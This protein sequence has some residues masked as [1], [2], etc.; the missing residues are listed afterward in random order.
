[1][2]GFSAFQDWITVSGRNSTDVVVQSELDW[3]DAEPY[4]DISIMCHVSKFSSGT[5]IAVQTSPAEDDSLFQTMVTFSP[6]STG[7]TEQIVRYATAS[8][9]LARLIRW[10]ATGASTGWSITF[11]LFVILKRE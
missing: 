9:P 8:V 3:L 11:R 2:G 6:S 7:I 5:I 4:S 10:R 1:M